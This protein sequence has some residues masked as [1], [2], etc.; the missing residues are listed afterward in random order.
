MQLAERMRQ[1]FAEHCV[2]QHR[3][4][5]SVGVAASDQAGYDLERLLALAD[6]AL[7]RAKHAGRNRVMAHGADMPPQGVPSC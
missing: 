1:G 3:H 6:A 5:V 4:T 2:E 7:Y